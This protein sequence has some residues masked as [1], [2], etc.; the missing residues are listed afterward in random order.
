[1]GQL[2]VL[3]ATP[4]KGTDKADWWHLGSLEGGQD[5]LDWGSWY[6]FLILAAY[7]SEIPLCLEKTTQQKPHVWTSL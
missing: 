3:L 2:Y 4:R 6:T 1:M 7:E 5:H